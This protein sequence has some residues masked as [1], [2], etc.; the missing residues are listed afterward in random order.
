MKEKIFAA[1]DAKAQVYLPIFQT[2]TYGSAERS[3]ADAVNSPEHQFGKHP[4]DYTL[5]HLGEID[6][7]TGVIEPRQP[8]VVATALQVKHGTNEGEQ[9]VTPLESIQ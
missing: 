8:V 4:E 2:G 5:M 3:F 7:E 9:Q 6:L 1:F